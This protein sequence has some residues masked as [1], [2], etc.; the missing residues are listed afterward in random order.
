MMFYLNGIFD[1]N[2]LLTATILW[3]YNPDVNEK[4]TRTLGGFGE[5]LL[6]L[7]FLVIHIYRPNEFMTYY[8]N[9]GPHEH[10]KNK[11]EIVCFHIDNTL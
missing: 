6:F 5:L 3:E 10:R 7:L 1:G 2:H 9:I 4:A 8:I 11:V